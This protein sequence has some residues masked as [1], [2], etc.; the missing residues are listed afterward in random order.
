MEVEE[1]GGIQKPRPGTEEVKAVPKCNLEG[2]GYVLECC[3]CKRGCKVAKYVA[4]TS[5]SPYQRGREHHKEIAE[6]KKTHPVVLH[7]QESHKGIRQ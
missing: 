1:A 6:A 7:F 5:R 3:S 2:A 4:K